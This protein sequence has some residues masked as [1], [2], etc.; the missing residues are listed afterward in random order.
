MKQKYLEPIAWVYKLYWQT[1]KLSVIWFG[2]KAIFDGLI[3][4]FITFCGAKF[5]AS[6]GLIA[7][8]KGGQEDALF[9]IFALLIATLSKQC[10]DP[11][12]GFI[13]ERFYDQI[14]ITG[15]EQFFIKLYG[16]NQE[17][18]D[19]QEFNTKIERARTGFFRLTRSVYTISTI[20]SSIISLV[21]SIGALIIVSPFLG[22]IILITVV[23]FSIIEK[24]ISARFE[25]VNREVEPYSRTSSRISWMLSDPIFMPEIRLMQSFKRLIKVWKENSQI[26]N[27]KTQVVYRLNAKVYAGLGVFNSVFDTAIIIYLLQLVI[28]G[29]I[30][31]DK[32]IFLRGMLDQARGSV[33]GL[34]YSF[35]NAYDDLLALRNYSEIY[36]TLPAIPDGSVAVTAP[37]SIEFKNVSFS[38]PGS[39]NQVIDN[40]SFTLKAGEKLAIVGENGAGKTT[41]VKLIQRQYIPN[42]GQILINGT[43]IRNIDQKQY[44]KNICS[45]GQEVFIIS[46]LS[47]KDNLTLSTGEK[48]SDEEIFQATDMADATKFI[49]KLDHGLNTILDPSFDNGTNLSGG[50]KQRLGIA[51]TILRNSDLMIL[52][53]PTS[54]IDSK[55]EYLIFNNIF[56]HHADKTSLIISHR[57][58]TVRRANKIIV[59]ESGK[60][61]E[62]G[63]HEELIAIDGTYKDM[64]DKQAEGY[65]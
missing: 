51:R 27:E 54:A 64:F 15:N 41:L 21:G 17:Q 35:K 13:T 1:S 34:S 18:F 31:F 26:V 61:T 42:S 38:Y 11:I 52:D 59:L 53:E 19:D 48:V 40:V 25:K 4:I 2:F 50:Q 7:V 32:F 14:N 33:S 46:Y 55:A 60:I 16:F 6:V 8:Q 24:K 12:G 37:M 3:N 63:S 62:S 30:G 49:R 57:F 43:D 39:D 56:N 45:L 29:A 36:N 5:I 20:A 44:L 23:P 58:S 9:W 10:L 22:F 65:R 28:A 47:I